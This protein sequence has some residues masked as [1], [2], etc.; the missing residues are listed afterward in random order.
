MTK[1]DPHASPSESILV[2]DDESSLRK[3]VARKLKRFGYNVIEAEDA[4]DAESTWAGC[5][6]NVELLLTDL[7]MPNGK[8]GFELARELQKKRPNLKV[9]F[10]TGYSDDLLAKAHDFVEDVDYVC[11]PFGMDGLVDVIRQRLDSDGNRTV[12]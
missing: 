3:L 11:K 8:N 5:S 1:L 12:L 6:S 2:V 9:V 7:R 4:P 10:M